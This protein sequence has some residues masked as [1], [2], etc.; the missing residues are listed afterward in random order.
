[1]TQT[2]FGRGLDQGFVKKLNELYDQSDSWWRALVDDDDLFLAV[3]DN[4]INVYYLGCSLLKLTWKPGSGDVVGETHYK[5]LLRPQLNLYVKIIPR[6]G[7][8]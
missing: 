1:M 8:L 6:R 7:R 3:R 2:N 5:Y 4:Y